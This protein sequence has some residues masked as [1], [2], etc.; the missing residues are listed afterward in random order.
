MKNLFAPRYVLAV[1]NLAVSKDFYMKSLGFHLLNEYPGWT[2]LERDNVVLMLGECTEE[3]PAAQIG[4]HSYF[5]YIEVND[6]SSLYQ[7]FHERGVSFIKT[8]RDEVWGM[9]EFGL[10]TVDGHRIMFGQD[11]T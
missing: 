3:K 9:R 5:A 8:I 6:A 7:E 11:L 2:F 10:T 1:Q 4:D